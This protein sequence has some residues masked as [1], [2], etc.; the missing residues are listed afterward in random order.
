MSFEAIDARATQDDDRMECGVCW[1]VYAPAQGDE[2]WQ[3]PPGTPFARLPEEWR[4][5]GCDGARERF[6]RCD[7]GASS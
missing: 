4:C 5:P 2:A 3:V 1:R 6:L 7:E